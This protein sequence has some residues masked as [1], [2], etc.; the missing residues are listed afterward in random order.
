MEWKVLGDR[1]QH[2]FEKEP[3]MSREVPDLPLLDE[4][5][6]TLH[7]YGYY[8]RLETEHA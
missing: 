7:K 8:V 1:R 2:S 5:G 3:I 4:S 6:N